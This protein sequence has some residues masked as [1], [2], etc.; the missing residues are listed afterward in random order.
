MTLAVDLNVVELSIGRQGS[1]VATST[2]DY[3]RDWISSPES[4]RCLL[5]ALCL[6]NLTALTTV[7]SADA[8][9]TARV[10]F[11]AAICWYCYMHYLPWCTTSSESGAPLLL[12]DTLQYLMDL[13]EVRLLCEERSPGPNILKK[14]I[15]D[16]KRILGANSA[17]MKASTLC[18]LESTLRRLGT[19]GISRKFA[20]IIQALITGEI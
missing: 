19:S 10:L 7:V 2:L 1:H 14:S 8:I 9:H 12:D 15:S 17:D 6:Q 18:V 4:K 16:L 13:P 11:A 20:D 5:H 3:V